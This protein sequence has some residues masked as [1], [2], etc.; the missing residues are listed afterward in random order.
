[1]V[2][3]EAI[4]MLTFPSGPAVTS[5]RLT[6]TVPGAAQVP[7]WMCTACAPGVRPLRLIHTVT[8]LPFW[9]SS[10]RPWAPLAPLSHVTAADCSGLTLTFTSPHE[11]TGVALADGPACTSTLKPAG[12]E[13]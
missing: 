8:S 13:L 3:V 1:M 2:D 6:A 5:P 12:T 10:A 11:M 4:F 7:T 9:E